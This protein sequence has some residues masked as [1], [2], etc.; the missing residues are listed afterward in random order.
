MLQLLRD[1]GAPTESDDG[2]AMAWMGMPTD[3]EH[4]PGLA[5]DEQLAELRAAT[6][7]G[8][9]RP[10]HRPDGDA[11]PGRDRHGE[12]R[13]RARQE[14]RRPDVRRRPGR[15]ARPR[16]S[17]SSSR[18]I[19]SS[20][21]PYTS[22]AMADRPPVP[23][24]N[25]P[26]H[27]SSASLPLPCRCL[28]SA[29]R[30]HPRSAFPYRPPAPDKTVPGPPTPT[31][32]LPTATT[33]PTITTPA[34]HRA[35]HRRPRRPWRPWPRPGPAIGEVVDIGNA[36]SASGPG[37]VPCG[38]ARRHPELLDHRVPGTVR[39]CLPTA[40]GRHIR[41]L[42]GAH[43]QDPG[44][45]RLRVPHHLPGGVR[46]RRL[47]LRPGRLPRL[48]RRRPR[49]ARPA[50]RRLRPVGGGRS[51]GPRPRPR[52]P[53]AHRRP[54]PQR[55]DCL[56]RATSRLLLRGVVGARGAR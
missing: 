4:M 22:R 45:R 51:D 29:C 30:L 11:P 38:R 1:M 28:P 27:A 8:G 34:R 36:K 24:G 25:G 3:D 23:A 9:E 7:V 53:G 43:Q 19:R 33:V 16:R 14:R 52:H 48:R 32:T 42:P 6:G 17:P 55:P 39:R 15:G 41:R 26:P 50:R 40:V 18:C 5:T 10:V 13:R 37:L 47:L 54:R 31:T 35:G 21:Q 46:L 49:G 56:H 2:Q 12:L 20:D 44:V